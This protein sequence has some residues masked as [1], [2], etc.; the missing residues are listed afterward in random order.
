[1]L[2][3]DIENNGVM[4]YCRKE[5]IGLVVWSPLA[6]G[7]LTG[8]YNKKKIDRD[9]RL[10][11]EKNSVFVKRIATEENLK[12]VERLTAIAG[13]LNTTASNVAL[14]WCLR[15]EI[16]SSVITSATKDA[17]L[18]ENI[19]ASELELSD[20]TLVKLEEIFKIQK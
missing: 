9:S 16:V 10:K 13:E 4:D 17:Q 2:Y 19:K 14:A 6:Q 18:K 8:K 7:V 1:M 20:S 11:D 5:G 12:K 15:K 3:R